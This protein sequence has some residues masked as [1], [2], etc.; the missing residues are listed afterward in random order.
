MRDKLKFGATA[1]A[2]TQTV[3]IAVLT[4]KG[5]LSSKIPSVTG[6]I[7]GGMSTYLAFIDTKGNIAKRNYDVLNNAAKAK[8]T[9]TV[10]FRKYKRPG[11]GAVI[12]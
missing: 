2:R 4:L 1:G 3:Y 5:A 12:V 7:V 6:S 10:T 9:V 11:N 8:R